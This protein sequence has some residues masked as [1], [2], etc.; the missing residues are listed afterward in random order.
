MRG[1]SLK[2]TDTASNHEGVKRVKVKF[3]VFVTSGLVGGEIRDSHSGADE[4]L[5]LTSYGK[6]CRVSGHCDLLKR[7]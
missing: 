7:R 4:Y 5:R 6:L 3:H 1:A 2:H